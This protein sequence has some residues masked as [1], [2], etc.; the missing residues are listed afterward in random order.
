MIRY[1]VLRQNL[2]SL[3]QEMQYRIG[4]EYV[5]GDFD[6]D[7]SN[8]CSNGFYATNLDGL[9]YSFRGREKI[10]ECEVSGE[11]VE[12]D[13]FKMRYEKIKLTKEVHPKELKQLIEGENYD[14]NVYE[15]LFPDNPFNVAYKFDTSHTELVKRWASVGDSV[16]ASVRASVGASVWD[17]VGAFVG[18]SVWDSVGDSVRASVGASVWA[19]IS[20]LFPK[21]KKWKYIDHVEGEN[22]FQSAIDLWKLGALTVTRGDNYWYIVSRNGIEWEGELYDR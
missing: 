11:Q 8:N 9:V 4:K 2:Q 1:K 19:Y 13:I 5:C 22:P 18:D 6:N 15:A 14:W 21:I 12:I 17:S 3:F 10:L 20:T 7:S 16:W